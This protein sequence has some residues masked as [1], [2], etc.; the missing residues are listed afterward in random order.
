MKGDR[1]KEWLR[2]QKSAEEKNASEMG[3]SLYTYLFDNKYL[4]NK[5]WKLY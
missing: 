2:P 5:N 3:T 4:L 1:V